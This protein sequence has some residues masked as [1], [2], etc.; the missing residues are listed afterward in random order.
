MKVKLRLGRDGEGR[1]KPSEDEDE[2]SGSLGRRERDQRH[3]ATRR[4]GDTRDVKDKGRGEKLQIR[5]GTPL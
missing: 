2:G 4:R 1:E 3:C 5:A